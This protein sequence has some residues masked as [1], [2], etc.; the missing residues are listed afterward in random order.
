MQKPLAVGALVVALVLLTI[1]SGCDKSPT[2][3]GGNGNATQIAISGPDT[4]AP[5]GQVQFTV[6]ATQNGARQGAVNPTWRSS[7]PAIA[8]IDAS[9]RATGNANG[10]ATITASFNG[11]SS[12]KGI[13]VLPQGTFRVRGRVFDESTNQNLRSADVRVRAASGVDLRTTTSPSGDFVLY[14]VPAEAELEV[15]SAGYSLYKEVL[16]LREHTTLQIRLKRD[17]SLPPVAGNYTLAVTAATCASN[18]G[19]PT[20]RSDLRSRTYGA[21]ITQIGNNTTVVLSNAD[22]F[23]RDGNT[24]NLFRA[25]LDRGVLSL[26]LYGP[27]NYYYDYYLPFFISDVIERLNDGTFLITS[28]YGPVTQTAD[29]LRSTIAGGLWHRETVPN[30]KVLG[31]C[32]GQVSLDFTRQP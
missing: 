28:G 13:V 16:Q 8:S 29:G 2:S 12:S 26:S 1:A 22:F 25:F 27:D 15:T 18:T 30:G 6:T 21:A 24:S 20:L 19:R 10:E 7:N 14:G 23:S 31:L 3:P 32:S 5:G 4:I 11:A 9:G 17:T